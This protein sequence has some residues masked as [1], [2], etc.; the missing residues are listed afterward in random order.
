MKWIEGGDAGS[1]R[2]LAE[3][4]AIGGGVVGEL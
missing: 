2:T 1:G 4:G 3:D